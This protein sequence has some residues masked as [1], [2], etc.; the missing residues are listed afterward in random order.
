MSRNLLNSGKFSLSSF[1]RRKSGSCDIQ[2][3]ALSISESG[4]LMARFRLVTT[5]F[6]SA[7]FLVASV[8]YRHAV[9]YAAGQDAVLHC[10]GSQRGRSLVSAGGTDGSR[11]LSW[12]CNTDLIGPGSP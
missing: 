2:S 7:A 8:A 1:S 4:L 10:V 11:C 9:L 5:C 6:S 3:Y 12:G